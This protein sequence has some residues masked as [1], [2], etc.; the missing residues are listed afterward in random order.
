M[1]AR[2]PYLGRLLVSRMLVLALAVTAVFLLLTSADAEAK[3]ATP[4]EHVV[5]PGET[6]WAL[7]ATVA[8]EGADVRP[9]VAD[10]QELNGLASATIQPGQV[11]LLPTT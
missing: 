4:V 3:A 2:T 7:A 11:L 10:I 6:L 1:T 8:D 9:I 5:A